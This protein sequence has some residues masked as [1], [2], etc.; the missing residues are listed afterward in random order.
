MKEKSGRPLE[1]TAKE[2]KQVRDHARMK[3]AESFKGRYE[4]LEYLYGSERVRRRE[5]IENERKGK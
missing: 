1:M 4:M 2:I 5:T 3:W